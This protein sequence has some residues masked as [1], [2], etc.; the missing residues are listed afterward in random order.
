MRGAQRGRVVDAVADHADGTA[1]GL[2]FP[3]Y[4]DFILGAA[5]AAR[6][7][8]SGHARN[9]RDGLA[10]VAAEQHGRDAELFQPADGLGRARAHFV[11]ERREAR[12][13]SVEREPDDDGPLFRVFRRRGLNFGRRRRASAREQLRVAGEDFAPRGRSRYAEPRK[14]GKFLRLAQRR[15]LGAASLDERLAQRMLGA[16]LGRRRERKQLRVRHARR[17]AAHGGYGGLS[18]GQRAGFVEGDVF[19]RGEPLERVALAHEDAVL[20]TVTHRRHD[21]GRRRE[22]ERAGAEDDENRDAAYRLA[23]DEP[24]RERRAQRGDDYP[25]RPAVG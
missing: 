25:S 2:E 20:R 22:H 14:H 21:G 3:D 5:F 4:P 15:A 24:D 11:R 8:D 7:V 10:A 16:Q 17:E 6:F 9:V 19:D 23:R 13:F 1:R 12:A 18:V